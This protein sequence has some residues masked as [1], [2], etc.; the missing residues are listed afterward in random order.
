[1]VQICNLKYR[2]Q[3]IMPPILPPCI[4]MLIGGKEREAGR[5]HDLETK[6]QRASLA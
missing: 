2:Y 5:R 6:G 3:F 4:L 1:M